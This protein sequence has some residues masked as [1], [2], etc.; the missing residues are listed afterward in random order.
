MVYLRQEE[1]R[2]AIAGD[3]TVERANHED[4]SDGRVIELGLVHFASPGTQERLGVDREDAVE[5]AGTGQQLDDGERAGV[6]HGVSRRGAPWR[7]GVRLGVRAPNIDRPQRVERRGALD[8]RPQLTKFGHERCDQRRVDEPR[9]WHGGGHVLAVHD[10]AAADENVGTRALGTP[11]VEDVN[12]RRRAR[13]V[14]GARLQ[15]RA[16]RDGVSRGDQ[17]KCQQRAGLIASS[18]RRSQRGPP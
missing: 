13:L 2:G 15:R 11:G 17:L 4:S 7:V 8:C 9:A 3:G 1:P 12:R 14:N 16:G 5:I 10:R 6:G 18:M